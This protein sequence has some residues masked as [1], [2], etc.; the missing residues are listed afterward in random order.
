MTVWRSI[1]EERLLTGTVRSTTASRPED[2]RN[3]DNLGHL[4]YFLSLV[5]DPSTEAWGLRGRSNRGLRKCYD[6]IEDRHCIPV[7]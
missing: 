1:L 4:L 3:F 2:S 5:A 7:R 6:F